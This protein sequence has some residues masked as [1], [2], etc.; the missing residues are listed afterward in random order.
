M[1]EEIEWPTAE[2][3]EK[4]QAKGY[5]SVAQETT[6]SQDSK[7]STSPSNELHVAWPS[8]PPPVTGPDSISV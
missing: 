3:E 6:S 2:K 1:D 4:T 5:Q 8:V 7:D